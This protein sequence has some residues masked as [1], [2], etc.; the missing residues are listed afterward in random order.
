MTRRDL[1]EILDE[2]PYGGQPPRPAG[3]RGANRPDAPGRR[4]P[5]RPDAYP[6]PGGYDDPAFG[7]RRSAEPRVGERRVG[8]RRVG[9]SRPGDRGGRA[10]GDRRVG[11]RRAAG[12]RPYSEEAA[13]GHGAAYPDEAGYGDERGYGGEGVYADGVAY[14]E[15]ADERYQRQ[16]ALGP[17]AGRYDDDPS[18]D[19][20]EPYD[21]DPDPDDDYDPDGGSGGRGRAASDDGWGGS[22]DDDSPPP[23]RRGGRALPKLIAI[24][25]VVAALLGL[26]IVGVGKLVGHVSGGSSAADFAGSGDGIAVVRIPDGATASQI[27]RALHDANVTASV[28]AFV[29][30]AAANPKS[31]GIQPGTYRL[32][33]R[34]SAQ[35]ALTAL[36]DPASGAPFRFVIKEGMT[37]Q[38]VL[39]GIHDRLGT[40][41]AD[42]EAIVRNPAQLGV[43]AYA[44]TLEGYLFP[45]TYDITPGQSPVQ[46]L[47]SFVDRF[48]TEAAAINLEQ[49]AA[50][51]NLKPAEIV[52]IASIIEKE[53]ANADEGPKVARVIYNRLA[54]TTGGFRRLDMDSTTR[55]AE[56][57]YT[58]PL[59]QEQLTRANPYNT[60]SVAGLPPG[61]ISNPGLW[62]LKSALAPA[63]GTWLYFVSMPRSNVTEFATTSAE[64]TALQA[65]YRAEGG[66][67]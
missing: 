32:R 8:E 26:G 3:R 22:W 50:A 12:R 53:V 66:R 27:A 60:R 33:S 23:R 15:E 9:D 46:L 52:T 56:D 41:M 2:D 59:S 34:M 20:G 28:G 29:K 10:D 5:G 7:G 35:A 13:Y 6:P 11:D 21:P 43:P 39:A 24:L 49:G 44:P 65:R 67:E 55:Y 42:L 64:W 48:R 18:Y 16:S 62:A 58:G 47:S 36:L 57:E 38:A 25:V 63:D 40:P 1:D 4:G 17:G 51:R 30:A 54:D 31:L 45:S 19:P 37:V 61:A 14:P